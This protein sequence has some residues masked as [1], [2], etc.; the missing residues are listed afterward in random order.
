MVV[1]AYRQ[2]YE[3]VELNER[4]SGALAI[5]PQPS[6]YEYSIKVVVNHAA[7]AHAQPQRKAGREY[8]SPSRRAPA[9]TDSTTTT[10]GNTTV[11]KAGRPYPKWLGSPHCQ[12]NARQ[13]MTADSTP[14]PKPQKKLRLG[15]LVPN[16]A[17]IESRSVG[18]ESAGSRRISRKIR[19]S[20]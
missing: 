3:K 5:A 2:R 7:N 13:L 10:A 16:N 4:S 8:G 6:T 17:A 12:Y 20:I 1:A 9:S 14:H 18:S 11:G 19:E 15:S